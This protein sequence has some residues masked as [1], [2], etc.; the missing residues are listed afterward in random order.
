MLLA[1]SQSRS[2]HV[3][4]ETY[5]LS[6]PVLRE[7]SLFTAGGAGGSPKIAPQFCVPPFPPPPP[8]VNNDHSLMHG[9]VAFFKSCFSFNRNALLSGHWERFQLEDQD[10]DEEK[11]ASE[12]EPCRLL[13]RAL[14]LV[15][16]TKT[17]TI[18]YDGPYEGLFTQ[19]Q[20][21]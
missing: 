2:L 11:Q 17:R 3:A 10:Q 18:F 5:F 14:L 8:A 9:Q 16:M 19:L 7:W 15:C 1:V 20:K 21:T 6:S 4:H 12:K 13:L